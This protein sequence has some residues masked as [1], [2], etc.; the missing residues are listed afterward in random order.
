MGS[1]T[2][3]C[4]NDSMVDYIAGCRLGETSSV[5]SGCSDVEQDR[6]SEVLVAI[7]ICEGK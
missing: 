7:C 2:V 6:K 4:V 1:H 3:V 5:P